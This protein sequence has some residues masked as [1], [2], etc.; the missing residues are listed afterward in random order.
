MNEFVLE[1]AHLTAQYGN[2][3]VLDNVSFRVQKNQ[4]WAVIGPNGAGKSTL[5]KCIA[6]LLPAAAGEIRV[7]GKA[8]VNC[9]H[10]SGRIAS[11][12]FPRLRGVTFP[13]RF[14]STLCW[15]DIRARALPP[16]HLWRITVLCNPHWT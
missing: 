5:I 2:K 10:G 15:A 13:I 9:R 12:T 4:Q 3:I 14:T 11:R 7:Q 1:V 16:P 6:S 8:C